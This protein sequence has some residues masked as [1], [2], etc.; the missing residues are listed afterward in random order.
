LK[1]PR[2]GI[3]VDNCVAATDAVMRRLISQVTKDRVNFQ[4]T[5]I[6]EFDY[7]GAFC[8]DSQGQRLDASEWKEVHDRF[9][10]PSEVM[11]VEPIAGAVEAIHDLHGKY[12]IHFVTTRR[13]TARAAT[14]Q[15][16]EQ[17]RMGKWGAYGVHFV[18][19][20]EKH[21]VVNVAAAIDDD[22]VQAT[23][24]AGRGIRSLLLAHPWNKTS[25]K[26]LERYPDWSA[27]VQAL[28][29]N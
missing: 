13:P 8:Q 29:D 14:I 4:Y 3:D 25:D 16:L 10:E 19:H 21:E 18:A 9:S 17:I 1:R 27:I 12:D 20:R 2:L 7:H 24:F 6:V 28:R 23:L 11:A 22:L 5:D 15:W 26:F